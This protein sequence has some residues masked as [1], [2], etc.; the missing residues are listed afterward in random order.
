MAEQFGIFKG[1]RDGRTVMQGQVP[2]ARDMVSDRAVKG[3][4]IPLSSTGRFVCLGSGEFAV[5]ECLAQPFGV[6]GLHADH[7]VAALGVHPT[8]DLYPASGG[9]FLGQGSG[10]ADDLLPFVLAP[11]L[12]GLWR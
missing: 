12:D 6:I 3:D 5:P 1:C 9:L 8:P 10:V 7:P 2:Q 11:L 4:M